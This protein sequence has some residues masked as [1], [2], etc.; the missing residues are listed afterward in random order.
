MDLDIG[1]VA[2]FVGAW[3]EIAWIGIRKLWIIVAPFVGAWIEI[4]SRMRYHSAFHHV[5]P[6]V[7]A[8]IEIFVKRQNYS[9]Y[10]VAPFVGA[11][12]EIP[13][14]MRSA[15][16]VPV[17]PF[18]GAWIEIVSCQHFQCHFSSLPSWERGL[19]FY[20]PRQ[21]FFVVLSLP[22]WERGLKSED[23]VY[24]FISDGVAP[25]VGAWIEIFLP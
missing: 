7:G 16:I 21:L 20:L 19:K 6:F 24:K 12:I 25:F 11:W 13:P 18:V 22:S 15:N 3:I 8:W 4:Q 2:P 23:C 10:I 9:G 14:R 5:A 1:D 17:A